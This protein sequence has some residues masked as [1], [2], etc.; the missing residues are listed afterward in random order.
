MF[1]YRNPRR[2]ETG[3]S[4][5]FAAGVL[6][7]VWG[8]DPGVFSVSPREA[9]QM[10]PQQRLLLMLVWEALEDAGLP[11]S[12]LAGRNVGVY[13]GNSGVDHN[14]R[15]FFDPASSDPYMMTGN[16]GALL[17]N[18]ISYFFDLHGPSKTIDTACSSSIVALDD[19]VN[20][21][22]AGQIDMAIVAGVN[23][24][25]SPFPFV[26][27][28]AAT[29]LSPLGLCRPF[30]KDA[31][32][33]VR[34][35]GG[36]VLVLQR[37]DDNGLQVTTD[38]ARIVETGI[39]SD[40]RTVGVAL[41][42]EDYQAKLL[43]TVY[44]RAGVDPDDLMFV[45]AHGTGTR[46]GDPAEAAALG[47]VLGQARSSPLPIGSVKSNVGHL[48][49]ASGLVSVLKSMLALERNHLPASLHFETPNPDISFDQL[50]LEVAGAGRDLV[51][52]KK[53]RFAGVSNF[54]FGGTNAHVILTDPQST[55]P[56]RARKSSGSPHKFIQLSAHCSDAL[57]AMAGHFG[58]RVADDHGEDLDDIINAI[59]WRREHMSERLVVFGED[60]ASISKG[61]NAFAAGK[62]VSNA[63]SNKASSKDIT[64]VLVFSGNG[65]QWVGMAQAAFQKN[66]Q[67]AT[68]FREIDVFFSDIAG[69]SLETA[70]FAEDLAEQLRSTRVAQPLLFA[71]QVALTA[72]LR[73]LGLKFAGVVGHSVGEVAAAWASGA[74]SLEQAVQII[75][76]R[77]QCQ[78]AVRNQGAMA[79]VNLPEAEAQTLLQE[80]TFDGV[81][82]S[83]VNNSRSITVSG[84]IDAITRFTEYAKQNNWA[85]K[86]LEIEYPF[87][88]GLLDPIRDDIVQAL[89]DIIPGRTSVPFYSTVSGDKLQGK[90]LGAEYWW[91]NVRQP[92]RFS[93]AV[94]AAA[95]DGNGL[96]LEIGPRPVLKGYLSEIAANLDKVITVTDSL[97][98]DDTAE[99]DPVWRTFAKALAAGAAVDADK[100]FG[101]ERKARVDLPF[102]PW[103]TK[104]HQL[105]PSVEALEV[106]QVALKPHPL[107]GQQLREGEY[108]WDIDLDTGVQEFLND[109]KVDGD[110]VLPG[111]AFVEMALA[112]GQQWLGSER[113]EIR[114]LDILQSLPLSDD[115]SVQVRTRLSLESGTV[116]ISSRKR[117]SDD[118]WLSHVKC[119]VAKIPGEEV[120]EAQ[121]PGAYASD[122][123]LG[124]ERLYDRCRQFGLDFGPRFRRMIRCDEPEEDNIEVV[125]SDLDESTIPTGEG[126][127]DYLLH[128]LDLDGCFQGLNLLYDKMETSADKL[129]FLPVYFGVIRIYQPG[130]LV[131]TCRI[132]VRRSNKRTIVA[133]FQLFDDTGHLVGMVTSARFRAAALVQ[134]QTL[135]RVSY[136]I[137]HELMPLPDEAGT[138]L[139]PDIAVV[140][141]WAEQAESG[142]SASTEEQ[143]LLLDAAARRVAYDTLLL[144]GGGDRRI[145]LGDAALLRE[146]TLHAADETDTQAHEHRTAL[147]SALLMIAEQSGMAVQD[148]ETWQ[149]AEECPLPVTGD[150]LRALLVEEPRWSADIVLLNRAA[151]LIQELLDGKTTDLETAEQAGDLYSVSMLDQVA[152]SSPIA[153]VHI[154]KIMA[155]LE[156]VVSQWPE[157]RPLRILELGTKGGGLTRSLIPLVVR[158]HG[159]ITAADTS[160]SR[161]DRLR[162]AF[163]GTASFDA[164]LVD[165]DLGGLASAGPFDLI[166]SADGLSSLSN[167]AQ[168][169]DAAS[170]RLAEGGLAL[171]SLRQPNPY[172]DVVFGLARQWFERSVDPHFPVGAILSSEEVRSIL[173]H[174]GLENAALMPLSGEVEGQDLVLAEK[175]EKSAPIEQTAS[176]KR[177]VVI[178]TAEYDGANEFCEILSGRLARKNICT[179][180][181]CRIDKQGAS[182]GSARPCEWQDLRSLSTMP[183]DDCVTEFVYIAGS[184]E[185]LDAT[186]GT[187][188][189]RTK[190][191]TAFLQSLNDPDA[192]LWIIAPGGGRAM[193]GTGAPSPVQCGIWA[194]GRTATNEFG[195]M[196]IR[197]VDFDDDL[198]VSQGA[199]QFA[200]LISNPGDQSELVVTAGG[201]RALRMKR[202]LPD[203]EMNPAD[204]PADAACEL[205]HPNSG[206]LDRLRWVPS[207]RRAPQAGEVQ[208]EVV[209]TGLNFRDLMWAQGLLPEEALEDGFSGP[210]LGFECSGRITVVGDGVAGLKVG[211]P[212]VALGPACFASHITVA[213]SGV[214]RVP[215]SF[216]LVASAT[217]P[218]AFLTSYYALHHLGCVAK[219]EWV[220]I[221]GSSGAVGLAA[222]QIAKWLDA[223]VIATA[224]SEEKRKLLEMLGADAVLDSRSLD[225]VDEVREITRDSAGEGVDVVLNSLAG[226][227]MERSLELL[228]PF[229]RFLELGK[230]DYYGNTKIGLRPFRR[231]ISYFGIDADQL[232]NRRSKI[233]ERIFGELTELFA[234]GT[235]SLLPYRTFESRDVVEAFRLMQQSGH[236]GKIIVKAP[237]PAATTPVSSDKSFN[238]CGEG[239]HVITGGLGGFGLETA[240][241]LADHGARSI[242][243]TSRSG[244][245][246]DQ[247][248]QT[249]E[250]LEKSGVAVE[251]ARC[252]VADR[253]AME[254]L[255]RSLRER[256]PIKGVMHAAMMLE[257]ALIMNI[258]DEQIETVL[259]PK[260][261]G[262]EHLDSLT[263]QDELDYFVMFSSASAF[264]GNPGQAHYV[265][266]NAYLD[267]VA[268]RR[269]REGLKALSIGWGAITDVGVL[270]RQTEAAESIARHTGGIE[271]TGR[272]GL[273]LLGQL[274]ASESSDNRPTSAILAPINWGLS[275]D[276]LPITKKPAFAHLV[277]ESAG[278]RRRDDGKIDILEMISGLDE[279]EAR[280]KVA[281]LLAEEV[282][283]IFRMTADEINLKRPL[284]EI[285]M[286]SL[287][288]MELRISAKQ[289]LGV[290][291]PMASVADGT[292]IFDIASKVV[293]RIRNGSGEELTSKDEALAQ[294][295]VSSDIEKSDVVILAEKIREKGEKVSEIM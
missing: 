76:V 117:L 11:P 201:I 167:C 214:S 103:Q 17:S 142:A 236:V 200:T 233:C 171:F 9:M 6:D 204:I 114:D 53:E 287:M 188:I 33:Y 161:I 260:I 192:R 87:H 269:R 79:V 177:R 255:F 242:V 221:H 84:P 85:H 232:L 145:S 99:V 80:E 38:Y 207:K 160:K 209:A 102:Y 69:W 223:K 245:L 3:K 225:F 194:Y 190:S 24:L 100:V 252:D 250:R 56:S 275:A 196:D 277:R 272:Q 67:F 115:Y 88:S 211:D 42:S 58:G 106:F 168:V 89:V 263:R 267:G 248:V 74:L 4:Y 220:L 10:D 152:N 280:S 198:S 61:L 135:D 19:A 120:P 97:E 175:L 7:D 41:P 55:R 146:S 101:P 186:V 243:L 2:G 46:V 48:E 83:A 131:R 57:K 35:E 51:K 81:E 170:R 64:T 284:A 156:S 197:I 31:F 231:N 295:H 109:H 274:L 15:F 273:D 199:E 44:A 121:P 183:V 47:S 95:Q 77:S 157:G 138:T 50:N 94:N 187:A 219:D 5:S 286:D 191:L 292:A 266:A 137:T 184:L 176:P 20:A 96:F 293:E 122:D 159:R 49:P 45:E 179:E 278:G 116:E 283:V 180:L 28:S 141:A 59:A 54:G 151:G 92:V 36:V 140:S 72:S 265:M 234:D 185:G 30:D 222:L 254:T 65:S 68:S 193:I 227:A 148:G 86:L 27:F 247:A 108:V 132:F 226:E 8:F 110:V 71:L 133:D 294:Q 288:G 241:W 124:V 25:L 13:V 165:D 237:A 134:R 256:G 14:N 216:D 261:E 43:S 228:R 244:T 119:R 281:E 258:T 63:I 224:G 262:V 62:T 23:L 22:R 143:R 107:L 75:Y 173:S 240:Q 229:G 169:V 112:A 39:N 66:L 34:A 172:Y 126:A 290:D 158:H 213:G 264:F 111:A 60:A 206:S 202:G 16:A 181:V 218:V 259:R 212:V 147:I 249:L 127:R 70:L 113:V 90:N 12:R 270:T 144:L 163:S 279:V 189:G 235:F 210:T 230:R 203:G 73:D 257:D 136:S 271:F 154:N 282:A 118:D 253:E 78:E 93:D 37:G 104:T 18:R 123:P 130:V 246:N 125:V 289:K 153:Q 166:V 40:G 208:I 129:A 29:M 1:R 268:Y 251:V 150:L 215:E 155:I 82:V 182:N 291:I 128:P 149:I 21:L 217:M 139:T 276:F 178:A 98:R 195:S 285:G 105:V 164:I 174:S 162:V 91:R 205:Y 239:L 52:Q 32:G 238:A 26:G